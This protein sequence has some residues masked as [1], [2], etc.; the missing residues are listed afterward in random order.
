MKGK[1]CEFTYSKQFIENSDWL[2]AMKKKMN[3]P[4]NI[5]LSSQKTYEAFSFWAS[6]FELCKK[7]SNILWSKL[8]MFLV[9][10]KGV[11]SQVL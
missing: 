2:I 1:L 8:Y 11:N 4:V 6:V 5:R 9:L 7:Q 10:R 3:K